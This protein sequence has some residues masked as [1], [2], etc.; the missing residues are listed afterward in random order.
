M[1]IGLDLGTTGLKAAIYDPASG[2]CLAEAACRLPIQTDGEE[3]RREQ[4]PEDLLAALTTVLAELREKTGPGWR[5]VSGIGLATQGG[6]T[7]I[8]N[9]SSG[10]PQTPIY[11]W[12]DFRCFDHYVRVRNQRPTSFWS[13]F[14][15]R[16]DPGVGLGRVL[17]LKERR[18]ELF[19]A[20]YLYIGVGEFIFH[21]LTGTWRQDACHALQS[22]CYDAREDRLTEA[23]LELIGL[24]TSFY[25]PLRRAHATEPLTHAMAQRLGLPPGLPVAGPYNDHEAGYLSVQHVSARP[26]ECSLG[27][28]WV[29][30]FVLEG[31]F[32]RGSGIQL[33][34]PSPLGQG[35]LIIQALLTGNVTWDW[36]L[37]QFVHADQHHALRLQAEIFSERLLPP[38]GLVALPW[39]NRPSPLG[40]GTGSGVLYGLSPATTPADMLR[41]VA[42]GMCLEFARMFHAV[43][44]HG[45]V[46]SLVLCGGA[47]KGPAFQKLLAALFAPLPIYTL[48]ESDGM[49]T[50]GCLYP[51]SPLVSRMPTA[52]LPPPAAVERAQL[53]ELN[54]LY[55]ELFRRLY[56]DESMC[57]AFAFN[58]PKKGSVS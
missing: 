24:T 44:R 1:L 35:R 26:L 12:N 53:D 31:E 22:G 39:L 23:P 15:M 21:Q 46:D 45:L 34:I 20:Q 13:S 8:V 37:A 27:T 4:S 7:L 41:A 25:A 48:R 38:K 30:N 52:P 33:P 57:H 2:H 6:S 16:D 40:G 54:R 9:R 17:W 5:A 49:G 55:L 51:F 3:G 10:Q 43:G 28:A 47:S 36:A 14:S 42:V 32:G 58:P 29:G 18:P 56:A 19:G 50:R 11:L